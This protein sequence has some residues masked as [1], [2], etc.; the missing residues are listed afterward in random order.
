MQPDPVIRILV[1]A[2]LVCLAILIVEEIVDPHGVQHENGRYSVTGLRAG[3][4]MLVRV[5]SATGRVWKLDLRSE[6]G[7]WVEFREG[8][9]ASAAGAGLDQRDQERAD[10]IGGDQPLQ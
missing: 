5:D 8:G 6:T 10:P 1:A 2:I 7:A 9:A 4:P 3:G